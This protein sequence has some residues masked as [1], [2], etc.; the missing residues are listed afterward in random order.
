MLKTYVRLVFLYGGIFE[1][2]KMLGL[3]DVWILLAMLGNIAVT[4][5]AVIYGALTWN[6]ED[7]DNEDDEVKK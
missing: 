6:A 4:V 1:M 3:G 5:F 2:H 7:G